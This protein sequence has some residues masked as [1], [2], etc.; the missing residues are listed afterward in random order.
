MNGDKWA[1]LGGKDGPREEWST[2]FQ[3]GSSSEAPSQLQRRWQR[4]SRRAASEQPMRC[5]LRGE[6][7]VTA[8]T[9]TGSLV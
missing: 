3:R 7:L 1:I 5:S 6:A 4:R 9:V 8:T 2:P